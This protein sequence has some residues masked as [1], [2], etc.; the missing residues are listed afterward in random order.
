M[1][2]LYN[3]NGNIDH[4]N[5]KLIRRKVNFVAVAGVHLD[6]Y[7]CHAKEWLLLDTTLLFNNL[8]KEL[9]LTRSS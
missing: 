7:G 2:Y 4:N 6:T 3:P 5:M 8:L 1:F 9:N